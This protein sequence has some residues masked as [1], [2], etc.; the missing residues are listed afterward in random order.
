MTAAVRYLFLAVWLFLLATQTVVA[1]TRP[2]TA[3]PPAPD[4]FTPIDVQYPPVP[5]AGTEWEKTIRKREAAR[6]KA[7]KATPRDAGAGSRHRAG[8]QH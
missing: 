2:T 7:A 4:A 3:L 8:R 6:R 5:L 1:G